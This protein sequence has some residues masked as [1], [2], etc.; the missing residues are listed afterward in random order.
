[1]K[2][3]VSSAV[4]QAQAAATLSSSSSPSSSTDEVELRRKRTPPPLPPKPKLPHDLETML[5]RA[6]YEASLDYTPDVGGHDGG[7]GEGAENLY[8]YG[9]IRRPGRK[10]TIDL[11]KGSLFPFLLPCLASSLNHLA[12][13]R[14]LFAC[15][16]QAGKQAC[17]CSS[18][19]R[20]SF[21][22][23]VKSFLLPHLI[24]RYS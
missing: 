14:W 8:S 4:A 10:L 24:L 22:S 19:A 11:L 21:D 16:E 13:L 23:H 3:R 6:N 1:V 12:S 17:G 2:I 18:Y 5:L 20:F 9:S 15:R 7:S